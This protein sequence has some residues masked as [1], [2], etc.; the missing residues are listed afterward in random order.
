MQQT[1]PCFFLLSPLVAPDATGRGERANNAPGAVAKDLEEAAEPG[2][3]AVTLG[4][5]PSSTSS[6]LNTSSSFT[7]VRVGRKR[8]KHTQKN[9]LIALLEGSIGT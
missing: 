2:R 1:S 5:P 7:V 6:K 8:E 4:R 9:V 3:G